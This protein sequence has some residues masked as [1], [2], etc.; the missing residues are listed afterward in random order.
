M[1]RCLLDL[2][3]YAMLR[4][5]FPQDGEYFRQTRSEETAGIVGLSEK[6]IEQIREDSKWD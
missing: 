2:A 4:Y 6:E 3:N 1:R 5:M